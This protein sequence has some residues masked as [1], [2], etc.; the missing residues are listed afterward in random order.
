M[1]SPSSWAPRA[2]SPGNWATHAWIPSRNNKDM[3]SVAGSLDDSFVHPWCKPSKT[4]V[5][6]ACIWH[7]STVPSKPC[8][9]T[10]PRDGDKIWHQPSDKCN[11]KIAMLYT[12]DQLYF[13]KKKCL[14]F[15]KIKEI[16]CGKESTCQRRGLQETWVCSLGQGD[17]L[18]EEMATHSSIPAWENL[19][20]R[21]AWWATVHG[22]AKSWTQV[23][24]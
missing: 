16:N 1:S 23:S 3:D 9:G 8:P 19:M 21:G 15:L 11:I 17:L 4:H 2:K 13:N 20:D 7:F 6:P 14:N 5:T 22:V 24:T 10:S 18:A 12:V